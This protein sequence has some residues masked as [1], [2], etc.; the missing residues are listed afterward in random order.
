MT[1]QFQQGFLTIQRDK[2]A[3]LTQPLDAQQARQD[4]LRITRDL[5]SG[6]SIKSG[7]LRL[8]VDGTTPQIS[9]G[10]GTFRSGYS[11]ASSLVK[12]LVHSAY[13]EH[14]EAAQSL[15]NYLEKSH[16]IGTRS[17]IKLMVAMESQQADAQDLAQIRQVRSRLQAPALS[18]PPSVGK[19]PDETAPEL[20]SEYRNLQETRLDTGLVQTWLDQQAGSESST[21]DPQ[22]LA[23]LRS[24]LNDRRAMLDNKI[25]AVMLNAQGTLAATDVLKPAMRDRL[26]GEPSARFMQEPRFKAFVSDFVRTDW[27]RDTLHRQSSLEGAIDQLI[28]SKATV[29]EARALIDMMSI[30]FTTAEIEAADQEANQGQVR[31]APGSQLIADLGGKRIPNS[32]DGH[33]LFLSFG[34]FSNPNVQPGSAGETDLVQQERQALLDQVLTL[35]AS[36]YHVLGT[37]AQSRDMDKAVSIERL[38]IGK[39]AVGKGTSDRGWGWAGHFPLKAMQAQRPTVLISGDGEVRAWRVDGS[40][41]VLPPGPG[42]AMTRGRELI[43]ALRRQ[44]PQEQAPLVV[45]N[46][47]NHFEAVQLP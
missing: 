3:Q 2:S 21:L 18:Q 46:D 47:S 44:Q 9:T 12:Q 45:Y 40:E 33:C 6:N 16:K 13:G 10:S 7:Y 19:I 28:A 35:P 36:Q 38:L 27:G 24:G 20:L 8:H 31:V 30:S 22:V 32:G 39:Q 26:L 34:Y 5:V 25:Q 11:A 4:L 37:S 23:G 15:D 29:G 41:F 42:D 43:Q 1:I 17:L 14:S